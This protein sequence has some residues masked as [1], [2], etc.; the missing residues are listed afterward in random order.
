MR[1]FCPGGMT[2]WRT[3]GPG[4]GERGLQ[5]CGPGVVDVVENRQPAWMGLVPRHVRCCLEPELPVPSYRIEAGSHDVELVGAV[6][7]ARRI[8]ALRPCLL[9]LH[10]RCPVRVAM[11]RDVLALD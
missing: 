6:E 3:P 7:A 10:L 4:S 2:A 8:V 9:N 5:G 11:W 1:P